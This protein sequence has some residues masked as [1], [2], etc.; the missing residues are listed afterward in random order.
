M[1]KITLVLGAS[2]NHERYSYRAVRSLL[3]RKIPVIAIGKRDFLQ[4]DLIIRKGMPQDVGPVH[5]VA[6]YL[7]AKNQKEYYDYILSLK[8]A[9]IIFNPGTANIEFENILRKQGIE[10]VSDC[11]LVMLSC[12]KF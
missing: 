10:F 11:L 3:S 5:T 2:P 1:E 12:G 4:D 7:N 6:L 9:R 8:P